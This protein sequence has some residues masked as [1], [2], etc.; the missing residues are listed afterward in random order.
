MIAAP[1][2]QTSANLKL[3]SLVVLIAQTTALV[4]ILR[5]SRTQTSDGPRY[6]SSTAVLLAEIIKLFT[7]I[8]VIWK[9]NGYSVRRFHKEIDRECFSSQQKRLDTLKVSVPAICYVI[10]NNLLFYAL[11]KLDAATYQVT[12]QL[13]ILTTAMFTVTMLGRSLNA[14]KWFSLLLLTCGVA[15]VQ[16][17]A[18]SSKPTASDNN[19]SDSL[20]GLLAVLAACFSSGFAGVFFEKILKGSEVSLWMRNLQ[21]AFFSIFGGF[22]MCW[23]YDWDAIQKNGFLQGYNNIIWIV[24]LLQAYGGLV[25]ALVVKYADNILKG[26]AVSLSII[27]SSF[28]S[29]FVLNDFEPSFNFFAGATLVIFSTFLYGYERKAP[30]VHN[31]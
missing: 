7:C 5:Y 10:Q 12:Y 9:S 3:I 16:L 31:A 24:V 20:M 13:K 27:L 8:F 2:P 22:F 11:S 30:P 26:F 15:L 28:M 14:L 17:P 25:I 29:W 19:T 1:A 23:V 21:L 18:D 6:L 4:L